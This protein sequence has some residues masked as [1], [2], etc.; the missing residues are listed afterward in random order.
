MIQVEGMSKRFGAANALR[1][2]SFSVSAGERVGFVG[3][4]GAGKTTAL[5]ILSGFLSPDRGHVKVAGFDVKTQRARAC[6]N[7][8]YMPDRAP[9]H[10][11]MR[12]RE[13]LRFRAML[14]G[15]ARDAVPGRI[16]VMISE[17][18]LGSVE[19]R[20]IGRLSRGFRQRVALAESLIADPSV[21]LLDEPTTGLDPLQRRAFRELLLEHG[22][23]RC[24]LF[25][26]HL[27]PEVEAVASRFLVLHQGRLVASGTLESLREQAAVSHAATTD[28][29]F[30]ALIEDADS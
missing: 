25:S 17:F 28:E 2:L 12:V 26:S 18:Q 15:V 11:D 3:P 19:H 5:R 7:L 4:N 21:L 20:L 14:K 16:D 24:I 8:G 22:G 27:L 1:E 10:L 30:A 13:F 6:A 29:V 9:L 23:S